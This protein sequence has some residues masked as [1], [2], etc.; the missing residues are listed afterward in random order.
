MLRRPRA[1]RWAP[2]SKRVASSCPGRP[3]ARGEDRPAACNRRPSEYR[4]RGF[5]PPVCTPFTAAQ[6]A[7][8]AELVGFR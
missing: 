5:G 1:A 6:A 8:L 3:P 4:F 7:K 2:L